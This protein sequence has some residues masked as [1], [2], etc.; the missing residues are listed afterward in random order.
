MKPYGF[1]KTIHADAFRYTGSKKFPVLSAYAWIIQYRYIFWLRLTAYL[2]QIKMVRPFHYLSRIVLHRIG[3]KLGISIPYNTKIMPGFYIGHY[4]GIVVHP[5]TE[6]G[7]NCNISNRVTIGI[8]SRGKRAGVPKIGNNVYIGPGA[9]I[10]GAIQIGNNVAIGANS[11]VTKDMPD[12]SV[13]TGV[14]GQIISDKGTDGYICN[15]DYD[16]SN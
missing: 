13:V 9:V 5:E 1:L 2:R 10:I 16:N 15:T 8:H 6:I 7:W 12:N 14:P 4:G 11:V 3:R